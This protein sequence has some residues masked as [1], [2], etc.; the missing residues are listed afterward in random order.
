MSPKRRQP[1]ATYPYRDAA[2]RVVYQLHRYQPKDFRWVTSTGKSWGKS[3]RRPLLY[4]LPELLAADP[5]RPVYVVEGE[6]D[7]DRLWSLGLVATCN[8]NGGG[9]GKWRRP[10]SPPL[11]GRSVIVI[12]D[13]DATGEEHAQD[14]AT[15]LY[16]LVAS[17]RVVRLPGLL[18]KGDVS[19][20]LDAGG[21]AKSLAQLSAAAAPWTPQ[22]PVFRISRREDDPEHIL[23]QLEKIIP[24][25]P[26][27]SA[28]DKLLL[29]IVAAALGGVSQ[30]TLATYL[31]VSERRVRQLVADLQQRG[32]LKVYRDRQNKRRNRYLVSL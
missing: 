25:D 26:S 6:K 2:G 23:G 32:V 12:P 31:G 29:V 10:H 16:P 27:L 5:R 24:A 3:R 8:D 15:Q 20:W 7:V 14:V 28:V 9:R 18:Y 19:D 17:L 1:V 21:T 4:R 11:R 30:Q 13:N 22:P